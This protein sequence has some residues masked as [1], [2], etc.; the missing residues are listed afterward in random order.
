[1]IDSAVMRFRPS[2][3]SPWRWYRWVRP[4]RPP[5]WPCYDSL[6]G[7]IRYGSKGFFLVSFAGCVLVSMAI[8]FLGFCAGLEQAAGQTRNDRSTA[9]WAGFFVGGAALS[10]NIILLLAFYMLRLRLE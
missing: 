5:G 8:A 1:M 10:A 3:R 6:L 4:W 2:G 7:R 9:S